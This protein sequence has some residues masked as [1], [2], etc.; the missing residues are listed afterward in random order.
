MATKSTNPA[1]VDADAA[2]AAL[3][4]TTAGMSAGPALPTSYLGRIAS[5]YG[6]FRAVQRISWGGVPAYNEGAPVPA[7][8]PAL[9]EWLAAGIVAPVE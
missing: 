7:S 5:D 1:A 3:A 4:A 2:A 8:H 6:Q 9:Q